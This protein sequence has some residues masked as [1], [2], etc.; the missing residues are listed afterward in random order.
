MS[1]SKNCETI[2]IWAELNF[3]CIGLVNLRYQSGAIKRYYYKMGK[4]SLEMP[5]FAKSCRKG[6]AGRAFK[7]FTYESWGA[8]KPFEKIERNSQCRFLK[9]LLKS[10]MFFFQFTSENAILEVFRLKKSCTR[11]NEPKTILKNNQTFVSHYKK[12]KHFLKT[13]CFANSLTNTGFGP[14]NCTKLLDSLV[15]AQ[16]RY[17]SN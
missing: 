14:P 12:P 16:N 15:Q 5:C 13:P 11:L 10:A 17:R 7:Y 4:L 3:W 2:K 1:E 8:K 9:R 6:F